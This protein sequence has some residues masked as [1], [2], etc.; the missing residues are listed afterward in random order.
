METSQIIH[1]NWAQDLSF[2]ILKPSHYP[3]FSILMNKMEL[4]HRPFKSLHKVYGFYSLACN[5]LS[6]EEKEH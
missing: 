5:R 3:E 2:P 6:S 1:S 4:N